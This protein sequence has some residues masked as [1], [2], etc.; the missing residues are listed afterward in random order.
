LDLSFS[1][2]DKVESLHDELLLLAG[3]IE[4]VILVV[5][6]KKTVKVSYWLVI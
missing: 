2:A 1:A 5:E 3:L 4:I 6:G